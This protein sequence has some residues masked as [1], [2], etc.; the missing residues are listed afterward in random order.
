MLLKIFFISISISFVSCRNMVS[1]HNTFILIHSWA[2][3]S[4]LLH[5]LNFSLPN[6]HGTQNSASTILRNDRAAIDNPLSPYFFHHSDNPGL[7]L[8]SQQLTRDNYGSWSRAKTK[9][10]SV[11]NKIGFIYG[12]ISKPPKTDQD[13]F[14]SWIRNNNIVISWILYLMSKEISISIIFSDSATEI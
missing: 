13:L 8:V 10:L 4:R 11:K 3:I 9:A 2:S 7:V 6:L 1:E 14:S 12:S 5:T